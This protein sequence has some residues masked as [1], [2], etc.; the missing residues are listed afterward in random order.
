MPPPEPT[1][2]TDEELKKYGIHVASRLQQDDVKVGE[3]NWADIDD[4]DEDWAPEEITWTDGTKSTI[5]HHEEHSE[6]SP[7]PPPAELTIESRLHPSG[8]FA[9]SLHNRDGNIPGK[10]KSPGPG[11]EHPPVRHGLPSG[12]GLILKGAPEK[13]TLVAKPP[14]PPTPVKSPWAALPPIDKAPPMAMDMQHGMGLGRM[15]HHQP[16]QSYQRDGYGPPPHGMPPPHFKE[17]AADDFSRG[18]F[19]D[20][21]PHMNRELFNSQSGRLEPVQDRRGGPRSDG[22]YRQAPGTT[23]LQRPSQMSDQPEPSAAFQ[24]H[25]TSA[26]VGPYGRRRGSSNV[27]GGSVGFMQRLSRSGEQHVPPELLSARQPS[28]TGRSESPV[29][30]RN[31]SPSGSRSWQSR[32]SPNLAYAAPYT[33]GPP[34]APA[35]VASIDD[36]LEMQKKIMRE[37]RELAKKRRLEEEEREEAA[38]RNGSGSSWKRWDQPPRERVRRRRRPRRRPRKRPRKRRRHLQRLQRQLRLLV[39]LPVDQLPRRATRPCLR[40]RRCPR[41]PP[42]A[43]RIR[44]MASDS[45]RRGRVLQ[46]RSRTGCRPGVVPAKERLGISG[47]RP[48]ATG[49]LATG[50][51]LSRSHM[52]RRFRRLEATSR[53]LDL[54]APCLAEECRRAADASYCSYRAAQGHSSDDSSDST[55]RSAGCS[56][57]QRQL[58]Q[59]GAECVGQRS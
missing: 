43:A 48:T 2:L 32:P 45:R 44:R 9:A 42:R 57:C 56:A 46:R 34:P 11:A 36:E 12:K 24:T 37:R 3:A 13:P 51:R 50:R 55:D 28:V 59:R 21:H 47:H 52:R 27:S 31:F 1:K 19:R 29:S 25:R 41:P 16:Y 49:A 23:V 14:A 38:R 15:Q 10:P 26:E 53:A 6:P 4:D 35:S 40:A 22:S 18:G 17:I 39:L 58:G 30:P 5:P 7:Q 54:L 20:G 8:A 33:N